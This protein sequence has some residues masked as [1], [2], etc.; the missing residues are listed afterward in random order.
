MPIR[1]NLVSMDDACAVKVEL[2]GDGDDDDCEEDDSSSDHADDG[3]TF[4]AVDSS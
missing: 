3:A 4:I 1:P 2:L